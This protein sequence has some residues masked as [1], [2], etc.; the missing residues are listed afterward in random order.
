MVSSQAIADVVGV[1]QAQVDPALAGRGDDLV[2]PA[3]RTGQDGVE[4]RVVHDLDAVAA[5]SPAA[6]AAA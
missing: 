4:E 3:R 5:R 1:D 6:S 2:G